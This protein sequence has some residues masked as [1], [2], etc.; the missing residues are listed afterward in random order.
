MRS[1]NR[2]A[3]YAPQKLNDTEIGE[4]SLEKI[5]MASFGVAP[6]TNE[7]LEKKDF[8]LMS[9]SEKDGFDRVLG[10]IKKNEVT[11]TY[12]KFLYL[13]QGSSSLLLVAPLIKAA[14]IKDITVK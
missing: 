14:H 3:V 8:K 1:C 7:D 12:F 2:F 6:K 4:L 5:E 10:C 11:N 9:V 13:K